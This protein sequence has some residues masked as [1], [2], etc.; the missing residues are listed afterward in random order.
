MGTSTNTD[1]S[2]FRL[3]AP[4]HLA[5]SDITCKLGTMASPPSQISGSAG[6]GVRLSAVAPHDPRAIHSLRQCDCA[7]ADWQLRCVVRSVHFCL[8]RRLGTRWQA[9]IALRMLGSLLRLLQNGLRL[10]LRVVAS[11][12]QFLGQQFRTPGHVSRLCVIVMVIGKWHLVSKHVPSLRARNYSDCRCHPSSGLGIES[13]TPTR[14]WVAFA[15]SRS[16]FQGKPPTPRTPQQ[17]P[18]TRSAPRAR[19]RAGHCHTAAAPPGPR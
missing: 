16:C 13:V 18:G 8:G 17:P 11:H 19:P 4:G 3:P 2:P 6:T 7:E 9:D 15:I 12:S 5:R 10:R 1:R 14:R